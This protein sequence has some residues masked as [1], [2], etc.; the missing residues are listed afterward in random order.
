MTVPFRAAIRPLC[1]TGMLA[2]S[3]ASLSAADDTAI[4]TAGAGPKTTPG[5]S[6]GTHS[7]EL[8][9]LTVQGGERVRDADLVG[10]YGQPR[11][12][13]ARRFAEVRTYVIPEGQFEFEYWLFVT[14]PSRHEKDDATAA[15]LPKPKSEVKQQYEAEIGLGHRLQLDLYQV[16]V[17]D[18][19][20]GDNQLDATKF[21]LRYAL[22]DWGKIWGNPT[23]YGEWEQAAHG[24]D[25]AEVKLLLCDDITNRLAWATNFVD[26]QKTGDDRSRSLEWNTA[27]GYSAIDGKLS[28][29]AELAIANVSERDADPAGGFLASRSRHWEVAVGPTIRFYPL[30]QAHVIVTELIGLNKD[31]AESKTAMIFGWEF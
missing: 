3:L 10:T 30:P 20:N 17:K 5:T 21:E 11:W 2:A 26:E 4:P 6:T 16:Y 9:P 12:S 22:A 13:T 8:P 29:G 18:G 24:A 31:A 15:G 1:A 27:V 7:W 23:L 28:V 19:S 25:S 14:T